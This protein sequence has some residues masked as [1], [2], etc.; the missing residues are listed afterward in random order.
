M[1]GQDLSQL[2]YRTEPVR[3]NGHSCLVGLRSVKRALWLFSRLH[4]FVFV[5][6]SPTLADAHNIVEAARSEALRICGRRRG[7][8]AGIFLLVAFVVDQATPEEAETLLELPQIRFA[9]FQ[10]CLLIDLATGLAT[11]S[12]TSFLW[13]IM[14]SRWIQ[15]ETLAVAEVLK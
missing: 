13:A 15:R 5:V 2:G 6:R 7:H 9:E 1:F 8:G 4:C 11:T 12:S 10:V 3:L 14:Y